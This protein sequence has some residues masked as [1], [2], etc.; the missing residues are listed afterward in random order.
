MVKFRAACPNDR[1]HIIDIWHTCFGDEVFII[2][3]FLDAGFEC[4]VAENVSG[5]PVAMLHFIP[6]KISLVNNMAEAVYLYAAATLPEYRNLGIM[7]G[8]ID[9]ANSAAAEKGVSFCILMPAN[10]ELFDFYEG[11]G[12]HRLFKTKLVTIKRKRLKD[13]CDSVINNSKYSFDNI[14]NLRFNIYKK[15]YGNVLWNEKMPELAA[16]MYSY[17]AGGFIATD[18]GYLLCKQMSENMTEVLELACLPNALPV[19]LGRLFCEYKTEYYR[20]RLPVDFDLTDGSHEIKCIGM[21]KSLGEQE[22]DMSNP[23][24]EFY[25]GLTLD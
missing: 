12:Y 11:L 22:L 18:N 24:G 17:N 23:Y 1:K 2:E 16:Y 20:F 9:Y 21:I 4:Y 3:K 7:S 15:K 8:L 5:Y 6:C 14:T 13:I 10:K 25:L 19:L